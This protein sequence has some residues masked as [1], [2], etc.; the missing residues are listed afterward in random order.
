MNYVNKIGLD[1]FIQLNTNYTDKDGLI[2]CDLVFF[3]NKHRY[4]N[5]KSTWD[6]INGEICSHVFKVKDN[7]DTQ[8]ICIKCLLIKKRDD[9]KLNNGGV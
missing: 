2:Y 9:I 6:G 1:S 4:S 3:K 7:D 5:S 8:Y